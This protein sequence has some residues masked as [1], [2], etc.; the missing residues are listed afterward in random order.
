MYMMYAI[1]PGNIDKEDKHKMNTLVSM[2]KVSF[3][4]QYVKGYIPTYIYM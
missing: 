4:K 3:W 1:V 2:F